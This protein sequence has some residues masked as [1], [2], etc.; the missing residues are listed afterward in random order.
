MRA[1]TGADLALY[2]ALFYRGLPIPKGTV[3]VVDL[4]QCSRPFDQYLVTVRLRGSD[5]IGILDLNA[6]P[7]KLVRSDI[8]TP[9]SG[10][11]VQIS[12]ARYRFDALLP[13]GKR[14]LQT[15]LEPD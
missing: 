8:D 13:A 4:V 6:D 7:K 10:R 9:G 3:D 1:A 12:G 5:I 11:V 2:S 14:I 15:D